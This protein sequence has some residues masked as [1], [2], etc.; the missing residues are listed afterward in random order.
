MSNPYFHNTL[1][2]VMTEKVG[3]TN[4]MCAVCLPTDPKEESAVKSSRTG[5]KAINAS[6]FLSEFGSIYNTIFL[7]SGNDCS[8]FS[9]P[10]GRLIWKP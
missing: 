1:R 8:L 6:V 10:E 3:Y 7:R 2:I 9:H 4:D 5:V